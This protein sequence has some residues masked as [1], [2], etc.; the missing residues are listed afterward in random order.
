MDRPAGSCRVDRGRR[1]PVADAGRHTHA[2]KVWPS[3]SH[4][5]HTASGVDDTATASTRDWLPSFAGAHARTGRR[6]LPSI[7]APIVTAC[8]RIVY[9]VNR[10]QEELF[11]ARRK[12]V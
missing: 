5:T 4:R 12:R 6:P 9:V 3:S 10:T 2:W 8:S 7:G 11:L 1:R